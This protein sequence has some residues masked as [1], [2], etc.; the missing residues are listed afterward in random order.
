MSVARFSLFSAEES[1]S[2]VGLGVA[3][4]LLKGFFFPLCFVL[5]LFLFP[6]VAFSYRWC[7]LHEV[8]IGQASLLVSFALLVFFRASS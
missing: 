5:F 1:C 7:V 4:C 6:G 2:R 8:L 3:S